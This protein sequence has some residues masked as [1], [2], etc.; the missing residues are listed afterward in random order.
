MSSPP[1][2]HELCCAVMQRL[3][4]TLVKGTALYSAADTAA[5]TCIVWGAG[6]ERLAQEQ[7]LSSSLPAQILVGWYQNEICGA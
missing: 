1:P 4:K 5:S 7:P 6:A 3:L 2:I